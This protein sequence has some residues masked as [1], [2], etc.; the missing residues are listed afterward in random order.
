MLSTANAPAVLAHSALRIL[1][2]SVPL[3][4]RHAT[5]VQMIFALQNIL[6]RVQRIEKAVLKRLLVRQSTGS[7]LWSCYLGHYSD[8]CWR[9]GSTCCGWYGYSTG[10]NV[11]KKETISTDLT[12]LSSRLA[13]L[14]LILF[15][16]LP[17]LN[18][19]QIILR[20]HGCEFSFCEHYQ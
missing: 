1:L 15:C 16:L 18:P 9:F 13:V 14:S 11:A 19:F 20:I 10:D 17:R 8:C 5:P 3:R 2:L 7:S 4:Y 6:P 12:F